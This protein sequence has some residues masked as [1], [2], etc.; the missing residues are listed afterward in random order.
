M[1]SRSGSYTIGYL[2]GFWVVKLI[3]KI[4]VVTIR[5]ILAVIAY[6]FGFRTPKKE[7]IGFHVNR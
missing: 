1:R 6:L 2:F 5:S 3:I 7:P 4:F